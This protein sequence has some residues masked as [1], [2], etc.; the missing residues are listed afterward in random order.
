MFDGVARVAM[1]EIGW[2]CDK[3]GFDRCNSVR[4]VRGGRGWR[5]SDRNKAGL[6]VHEGSHAGA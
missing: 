3:G 5:F 4:Y 2:R 1:C 6:N